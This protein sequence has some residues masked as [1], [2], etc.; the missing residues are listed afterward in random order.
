MTLLDI[1]RRSSGPGDDLTMQAM[2][3]VSG[4]IQASGTA[5]L[6]MKDEKAR[7]E[8]LVDAL[9]IREGDDNYYEEVPISDPEGHRV[10]A[11]DDWTDPTYDPYDDILAGS[12]KLSEKGFS[13]GAI[14][15][16][17]PVISALGRNDKIRSRVGRL[18][19]IDGVVAGLPGR[20]SIEEINAVFSQD[21]LPPITEYNEKYFTQTG[22]D[23]YLKRDV[24]V[25]AALTDRTETID[26]GDEE[27]IQVPDTLGYTGRGTVTGEPDPGRKLIVEAF[28]RK[29]PRIELEAYQASFPVVAE[30]EA[31]YVITDI[32]TTPA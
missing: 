8:A 31:V 1:I 14:Y 6:E 16:G 32:N 3:R 20:A 17:R 10:A 28:N 22:S 5:A 24:V 4:W 29:P 26:F 27:P 15:A 7:W 25:M 23:F 12:D 11:G 2:A 30:P 18:S 21:G 19:I 13:V 9:V